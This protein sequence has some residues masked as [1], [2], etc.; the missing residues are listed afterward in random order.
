VRVVRFDSDPVC[1]GYQEPLGA[2]LRGPVGTV[3]AID[4]PPR[5][6]ESILMPE[7][8]A[9][10]VPGKRKWVFL[11]YA[12]RAT[13]ERFLLRDGNIETDERPYRWLVPE[14]LDR[15]TLVISPGDEAAARKDGLVAGATAADIYHEEHPSVAIGGEKFHAE[16]IKA[17]T[18]AAWHR[19]GPRPT[20]RAWE[21]YVRAVERSVTHWE[22]HRVHRE[23]MRAGEII[24]R[25]NPSR[26]RR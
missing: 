7:V 21:V 12:D 19:C 22:D 17:A 14:E 1:L 11:F 6:Y 26:R 8:P 9:P 18:E 4:A 25:A 10:L 23:R 3:V 13:V 24:A 2:G 20:G 16:A 15:Y 5:K